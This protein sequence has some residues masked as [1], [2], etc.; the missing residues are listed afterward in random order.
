MS[1]ICAQGQPPS[2]G[3]TD[4]RQ[5]PL[6][7][8]LYRDFRF[9]WAGALAWAVASWMQ[10]TAV[11][12]LV[13]TLTDSAV[14]V[15]LVFA[16]YALP[17]L[18]VGPFGGALADRLNRK[19]LMLG[20]QAFSAAST[21]LLA[22]LVM[23]GLENL[24]A[25]FLLVL[26]LGAGLPLQ[27]TCGQTLIYDVVGPRNALN[28]VS[29]WSV[30]LRSV[31]ALGAIVGGVIIE[32]AGIGT[33][34]ILSSGGYALAA[35]CT[36]FI[37]HPGPAGE[38]LEESV[39]QNLTSGFRVVFG[40]GI[41]LAVLLLAMTAEAFGYG[42]LSVFPI[43]ADERVYGV[44]AIGLGL[45]TGAFGI[46]GVVG[47]MFL[48]ALPDLRRKGAALIGVMAVTGLLLGGLAFSGA[49]AAAMVAIAG[50]GVVLAAYD[51]LAVLLIQDNAPEGMRGRA[52]GTL[53]LTF[54]IG[55]VG[56]VALGLMVDS[57]GVSS[58]IGIGAV[59]VLSG[60]ALITA[61]APKLRAA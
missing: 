61:A 39:L 17:A 29:L 20:V 53:V 28:G 18:V 48:A 31:G 15:T 45:M 25:V 12:W 50:M 36:I 16:V 11:A 58:A 34:I 8:F 42:M 23:S 43:L 46:G 37:R 3:P 49:F 5:G 19:H 2:P 10:R 24:W 1:A 26:V 35:A 38:R 44:G 30:G 55:P 13:L 33:A 47:A 60:T 4:W 41:L 40:S 22:L 54:G 32:Y 7:S 51:A 59:V 57:I 56:P 52:M 27:F 21:L 14:F 6:R 9:I